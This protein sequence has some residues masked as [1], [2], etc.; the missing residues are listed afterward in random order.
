MMSKSSS[1]KVDSN[2]Q[3]AKGTGKGQEAD[4]ISEYILCRFPYT[5]TMIPFLQFSVHSDFHLS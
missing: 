3:S 1:A 2:G 5:L 4:L